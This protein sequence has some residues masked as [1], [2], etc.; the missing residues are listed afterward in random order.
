MRIISVVL[1]KNL[2]ASKPSEHPPTEGEKM[3]KLFYVGTLIFCK[4]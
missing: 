1:N 2:N 4:D 3:S